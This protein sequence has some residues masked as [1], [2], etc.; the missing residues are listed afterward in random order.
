MWDVLLLACLVAD[1]TVCVTARRPG[2]DSYN[3]CVV[4]AERMRVSEDWTK[5]AWP[6]VPEGETPALAL[7]EIAPGILVHKAAHGLMA[8]ENRGDIA[9]MAA[10]IGEEAVAVI[11]AGGTAEIAERFLAALRSRTALPLR[12]LILTHMHPDHVLGA[13]VFAEAGATVVA[14]A[15]LAQGLA[16]RARSYLA[17]GARALGPGMDGSGVVMP[18]IEVADR[19][20]I[21]LGGR[22]L[23]LE[24]HPVAHTDNDLTATDDATEVMF[25]GDLAFLG[26]LPTLDGSLTGWIDL[27][28]ALAERHASRVVL[29]HGPVAA[30]WPEA[31]APTRDYL[32]GLAEA[33]RAAIAAGTPMLE[34]TRAIAAAAP[35]GW[36]MRDAFAERNATTAIRELEW[37]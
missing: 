31:A 37:E 11:D 9:N 16:A 8:E 34:A 36:A 18:D 23:L 26:H 22:S 13:P 25:L 6:C 14:H 24:A 33:A 35:E 3:E 4:A 1:P 17:T 29:G 28:D 21:D 27:L 5:E 2:G 30:P 12:W 32:D 15:N 7:T 10:V 20:V 19:R